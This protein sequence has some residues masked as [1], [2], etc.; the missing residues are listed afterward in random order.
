M[1]KILYNTDWL[2]RTFRSYCFA[3]LSIQECGLKNQ[4]EPGLVWFSGWASTNELGGHSSTPGRAR[5]WVAGSIPSRGR[6]GDSPS[7]ILAYHWCFFLSLSEIN[8]NILK[9]ERNQDE[10]KWWTTLRRQKSTAGHRGKTFLWAASFCSQKWNF[11]KPKLVTQQSQLHK[12]A[13]NSGTFAA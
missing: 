5:A 1:K 6:A 4:G 7:V 8:K 11:Q 12:K 13:K 10:T 3:K 2:Q 9:K